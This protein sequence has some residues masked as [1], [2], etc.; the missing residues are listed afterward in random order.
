MQILKI[1]V[2]ADQQALRQV[3]VL[4]R[5]DE[6]QRESAQN[7]NAD[8]NQRADENGL[9]IVLAR[10]LDVHH[11]NT[12]HL[13]A[14]VKQEDSGSQHQVVELG[15]IG[16]EPLAHIHVV[17]ASR[18]QIDDAQNDQQTRRNDRSDHTPDF[19]NLADP[20]QSLQRDERSQPVDDEHDDQRENLVRG[21]HHVVLRMNADKGDRHGP[22]R[23]HG[24]IPDRALDPLEP[25]SEKA[26]PG[27]HRLTNPAEHAS[28]LVREHRRQL[29]GDQSRRNEENDGREQI[30]KRRRRPVNGFRGQ[31]PKAYDG[32]HVHNRE[33]HHTQFEP[34]TRSCGT[35]T[36][37]HTII[38][39][40]FLINSAQ[41]TTRGYPYARCA[42][43]ALHFPAGG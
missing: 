21:Q 16:K 18:T 11:M 31:S 39:L 9:R 19:G 41:R 15:Q 37:C 29:G 30:V 4:G 2:E 12:H 23:Q 13:H 40:S 3:D 20:R 27:A 14:R 8:R 42:Q 38:L 10:I 6:A 25:N 35:F 34:C 17:V 24:R 43:I 33:C 5:N 26:R 7:E 32:R 28:L 1:I 22:E 36:C